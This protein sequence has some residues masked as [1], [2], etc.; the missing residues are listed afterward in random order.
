MVKVKLP[1]EFTYIFPLDI[2]RIIDSYLPH[3][4]KPPIPKTS[5][6]LERELRKI[7]SRPYRGKSPMY[8]HDLDDFILDICYD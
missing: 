3:L 4:K 6:S 8:M 1:D 7:Q 2:L 5:P